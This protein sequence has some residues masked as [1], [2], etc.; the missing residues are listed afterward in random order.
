MPLIPHRLSPILIHKFSDS[1]GMA[2]VDLV[3]MEISN[4]GLLLM[5]GHKLQDKIKKGS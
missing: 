4:N 3:S 2:Q 5:E 1:L